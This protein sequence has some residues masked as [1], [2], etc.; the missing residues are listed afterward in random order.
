[1]INN[2][3]ELVNVI[4]TLICTY[5]IVNNI[6]GFNLFQN[7]FPNSQLNI[8]DVI[9]NFKNIIPSKSNLEQFNNTNINSKHEMLNYI[10]DIIDDD[11][12]SSIKNKSNEPTS[13]NNYI[14]SNITKF[15]TNMIPKSTQI[16]QFST[17]NDADI[18][19]NYIEEIFE[20]GDKIKDNND[21]TS[22][23]SNEKCQNGGSFGET[24]GYNLEDTNYLQL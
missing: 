4:L 11:L 12:K 23:Y 7:I 20:V 8:T 24:I 14:K 3:H 21:G 2:I 5:Y 19:S 17:I 10:N 13:S 1:M 16:E 22:L 6:M 9:N 15:I 18:S